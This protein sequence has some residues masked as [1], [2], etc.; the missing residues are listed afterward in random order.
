LQS[1]EQNAAHNSGLTTDNLGSDDELIDLHSAQ[2]FAKASENNAASLLS[3]PAENKGKQSTSQKPRRN[4]G[5]I[6]L[7]SAPSEQDSEAGASEKVESP[8]SQSGVVSIHTSAS[9]SGEDKSYPA[10]ILTP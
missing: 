10:H 8:G 6:D 9:F 7:E 2:F 3:S 1:S 5:P 4:L